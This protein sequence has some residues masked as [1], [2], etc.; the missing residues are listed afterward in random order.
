M[1]WTPSAFARPQPVS[2]TT[3]VPNADA[4]LLDT[5]GDKTDIFSLYSTYALSGVSAGNTFDPHWIF[6]DMK[7][8]P[9]FQSQSFN[10]NSYAK[11]VSHK[12]KIY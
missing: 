2:I 4:Y 6:F 10:H 1:V 12:L 9:Y 11:P 8:L 3:R 5:I 7:V